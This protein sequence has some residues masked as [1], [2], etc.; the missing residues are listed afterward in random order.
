MYLFK[1]DITSWEKWGKAFQNI[2]AFSLLIEHIFKK[3]GL[4]LY[5]ISNTTP[6]INAVFECESFI[7]KIY[8]PEETGIQQ[9]EYRAELDALRRAATQQV[10]VPKIFGCGLVEDKYNFNYLIIGKISGQE[11]RFVLPNY[12]YEKKYRFVQKLNN[13][14]IKMNSKAPI[15]DKIITQA[16][17]N[18]RWDVFSADIKN[19][20]R[21]IIKGISFSEMVYVH[22][23]LTG[24]N[25]FID[26]SELSIIDFGDSRPAPFYYEYPPIVFEAFNH[27]KTLTEIFSHGKNDF[28]SNLFLGTLLHDFGAHFVR[29]ICIDKFEIAPQNFSDI[30]EIKNYINT[31]TKK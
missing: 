13:I 30:F 7:I 26:K 1:K 5:K 27:D 20:V 21:T 23:D 22:G 19:Q 8:A 2:D 14:L 25:L 9:N 6:G 18:K 11:A 28:T 15:N 12:S 31:L 24:E 10:P 29:D 3:E 17:N 4:P 16:L